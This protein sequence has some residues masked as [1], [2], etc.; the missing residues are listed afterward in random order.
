MKNKRGWLRILEATIAIMLVSGVLLVMYSRSVDK[1]DISERVY[2]L[3]REVLMD[4]AL[5]SELRQAALVVADD[6]MDSSVLNVFAGE[7]IPD[8][9]EFLVLVCPLVQSNSCNPGVDYVTETRDKDVYVEDIVI[10]GTHDQYVPKK[11]RLF[12]W[13]AD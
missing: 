7:K 6:E 10:A 9:F 13:D 1:V 3:Q 11:V 5:D 8:A 2:S 4:I 12:V